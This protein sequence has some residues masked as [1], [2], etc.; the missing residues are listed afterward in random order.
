[1]QREHRLRR[2]N[3]KGDEDATHWC[4]DAEAALRTNEPN[5]QLHD[6]W[7]LARPASTEACFMSRDRHVVTELFYYIILYLR[8]FVLLRTVKHMAKSIG[9]TTLSAWF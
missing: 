9:T 6:I 8:G 3:G 1:V 5:E 4:K 2:F 7:T